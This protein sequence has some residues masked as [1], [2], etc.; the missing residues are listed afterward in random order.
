MNAEQIPDNW[1][2]PE[3]DPQRRTPSQKRS[4]QTCCAILEATDAIL[5]EPGSQSVTTNHIA[6]RAGVNIATLY[7]YFASADD[8]VA[9][10]YERQ[11]EERRIA[12][13]NTVQQTANR[14]WQERVCNV[15]DVIVAERRRQKS[16]S[17]LRRRMQASPQLMAIERAVSATSGELISQTMRRYRDIPIAEARM[18]GGIATDML[19]A[20][21]DTW[22]QE[23]PRLPEAKIDELK[24]AL[25]AYLSL[26]IG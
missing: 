23:T 22:E 11:A 8:V 7:R 5:A 24:K 15:V 18:A 6:Q 2:I 16:C 26:Y 4:E 19:T 1:Y 20:L 17:T 14:P 13:L 3:R 21:L 25:V 10:L 9:T 12:L